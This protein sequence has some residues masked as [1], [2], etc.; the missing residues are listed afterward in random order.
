MF[1]K[2]LFSIGLGLLILYLSL[3]P[4]SDFNEG[5]LKIPHADKI[6]HFIMYFTLMSV[7][8]FEN[9]KLVKLTRDLLLLAIIPFTYGIIIEILQSL[10]TTT[11]T[12]SI[13]DIV[14]NLAGIIFSILL[15]RNNKSLRKL[16]IK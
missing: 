9:R 14:F 10:L 7:I 12:G 1:I 6:A 5:F 2:N 4:G 15:W 8:I 16:I 3:T 13:Y 11:R